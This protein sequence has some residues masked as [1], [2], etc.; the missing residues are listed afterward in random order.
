MGA[1]VLI[2]R[3]GKKILQRLAVTN[4]ALVAALLSTPALLSAQQSSRALNVVGVTPQSATPFSVIT[5]SFDAP[6]FEVARRAV[7]PARIV[8]VVPAIQARFEWRD[9]STIRIV[10]TAALT[11]GAP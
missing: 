5:I 6:V 8:R 3:R 1:T 10:P 4:A 11:S 2:K 7:D 9:P